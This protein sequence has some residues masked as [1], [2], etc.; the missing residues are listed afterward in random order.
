VIDTLHPLASILRRFATSKARVHYQSAM[1][2][3]R[4][5]TALEQSCRGDNRLARC[6]CLPATVDKIENFAAEVFVRGVESKHFRKVIVSIK[7][8]EARA[9]FV[10]L[11]QRGEQFRTA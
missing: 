4:F 5:S 11:A 2:A 9:D 8:R 7:P 10:S 6:R 1:H 3:R